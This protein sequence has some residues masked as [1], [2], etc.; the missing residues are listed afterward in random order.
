MLSGKLGITYDLGAAVLTSDAAR[1]DEITNA[2][3][4]ETGEVRWESERR[5]E[6]PPAPRTASLAVRVLGNLRRIAARA[7]VQP[8]FPIALLPFV[9]VAWLGK[10]W[11]RDRWAAEAW[12][13]ASALPVLAFLAYHVHQ[14]FFAPAFPA[15]LVWTAAGLATAG[16]WLARRWPA[17][18]RWPWRALLVAVAASFAL[19]HATVLRTQLPTLRDVHRDA[20]LWLRDN[21][22]A[23]ARVLAY[24]LAVCV[25]AR[26]S[27]LQFPR[28]SIEDV[29]AYARERGGSYVLIDEEESREA[30]PFLLPLLDPAA[31]LPEGLER[32]FTTS[33]AHGRA[34]VFRI[35]P[36]RRP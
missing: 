36:Y 11:R 1:Y 31:N 17:A 27:C 24:E 3:D 28:A 5:F 14:R 12:L 29:L 19:A 7:A 15:L 25:W 10:S 22:P 18:G 23:D 26:R 34:V 21:S 33:D 16:D 9:F 13:W 35:V 6:T 20:G 4:P 2:I 30:R 32:V 8:V